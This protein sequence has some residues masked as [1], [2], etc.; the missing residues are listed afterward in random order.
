MEIRCLNQKGLPHKLS[1]YDASKSRGTF[2][3]QDF[4]KG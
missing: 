3:K 2:L 1:L 4:A